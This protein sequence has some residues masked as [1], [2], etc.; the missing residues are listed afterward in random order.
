MA[1]PEQGGSLDAPD[2]Y[3][4]QRLSYDEALCTVRYVGPLKGTKGTW[5]GVEW[6]D[7]Q[8]G[9]HDGRYQGEVLFKCLSTSPTAASFIKSTR[10]ADFRRTFLNALRFKY[11]ESSDQSRSTIDTSRRG[12]VLPIEISGKVAEE[13]GFDRIRDQQ[14]LL[15]NLKIVVLDELRICGLLQGQVSTRILVDAQEEVLAICP[16]ILELDIGWNLMETWQGVADICY[17]LVSLRVLRARSV[18]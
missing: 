13:V 4:G 2:F 1:D 10:K 14:S 5:L 12:E 16:H 18:L 9:K 7:S 3:S 6:D 17:P 11:T 15:E 8:R